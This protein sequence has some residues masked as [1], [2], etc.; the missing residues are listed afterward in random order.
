MKLSGVPRITPH[1]LRHTAAS[2]AVSSGQRQKSFKRLGHASVPMTLDVYAY[3][4]DGDL[5]PVSE[6]VDHAVS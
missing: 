5:D 6:A 3:L 2:F 1:E 4:F